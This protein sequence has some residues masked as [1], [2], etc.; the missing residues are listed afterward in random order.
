MWPSSKHCGH[1]EHGVNKPLR[2]MTSVGAREP[3]I[4]P[5]C[6]RPHACMDE[7][8]ARVPAEEADFCRPV[9]YWKLTP[10]WRSLYLWPCIEGVSHWLITA[11]GVSKRVDPLMGIRYR[12]CSAS[13]KLLAHG[14]CRDHC[15]YSR[16][17]RNC[18]VLSPDGV[19]PRC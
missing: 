7:D 15:C 18:W 13:K 9:G 16:H 3:G 1:P 2:L 5:F 19:L 14:H 10:S 8:D 12:L 11:G 17:H 4:M 6:Y